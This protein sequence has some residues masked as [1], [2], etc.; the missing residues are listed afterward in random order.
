MR[1]FTEFGGR[2]DVPTRSNTPA[3]CPCEADSGCHSPDD[4]SAAWVSHP[5]EIADHLRHNGL[6]R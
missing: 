4:R 5:L 1:F 3:F 2:A 6:V